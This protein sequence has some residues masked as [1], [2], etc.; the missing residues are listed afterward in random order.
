MNMIVIRHPNDNGKYLFKV[1]EDTELDA[2]TLVSC[3]TKRGEQPGVCITSSFRADP[4]VICP[5]W[6]TT[7]N[8]M[9]RVLK[10]LREIYLEWP[11]E[12]DHTDDED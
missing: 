11:K 8:E 9:K 1:P 5:L 10:V 3:D 4:S 7:P 6:N 12:P 2:G